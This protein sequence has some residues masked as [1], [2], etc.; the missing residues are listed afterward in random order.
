VRPV[1]ITQIPEMFLIVLLLI[2]YSNVLQ[3]P[4]YIMLILTNNDIVDRLIR[5]PDRLSPA[6]I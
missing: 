4:C 6:Y 5:T 2:K 1:S 3:S